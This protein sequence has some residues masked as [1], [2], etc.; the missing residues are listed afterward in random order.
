MEAMA[1]SCA[2]NARLGLN[3]S[4]GELREYI[5]L[6]GRVDPG[7][8]KMPKIYHATVHPTRCARAR[9]VKSCGGGLAAP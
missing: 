9:G 6:D 8:K 5:S 1:E 2:L 7:T 4:N 3:P